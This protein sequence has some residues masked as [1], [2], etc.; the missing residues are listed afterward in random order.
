MMSFAHE[1]EMMG[2]F[3]ARVTRTSKVQYHIVDIYQNT[4]IKGLNLDGHP[5]PNKEVKIHCTTAKGRNYEPRDPDELHPKRMELD[6]TN[7]KI[8]E[9]KEINKETLDFLLEKIKEAKEALAALKE[10]MN[11]DFKIPGK[12]L[13]KSVWET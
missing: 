6:L 8:K 7:K 9:R 3:H 12:D 4:S 5:A 11:L 1:M 10:A 2:V 13:K